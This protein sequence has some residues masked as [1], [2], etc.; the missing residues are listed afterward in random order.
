MKRLSIAF[1]AVAATL[2]LGLTGCGK[3]NP[4]A[5]SQAEQDKMTRYSQCMQKY[6]I[7]IPIPDPEEP[8]AGVVT[9]NPNDPKALAAQ[10]AC[11]RLAPNPQQQGKLT[12][13]QEDRALKLAECLRKHGI[14]AKDPA[15]G[16]AQVTLDENATYTEE[17]LVAAY[18]VCNK[19]VPASGNS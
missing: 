6:G 13:A 16:T 9:L 19:E 8:A 12:A 17:Q 11:G 15:P 7:N 10:A 4:P 3:S 1:L 18:T 14:N 5:A 2:T